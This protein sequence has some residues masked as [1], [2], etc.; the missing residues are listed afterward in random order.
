MSTMKIHP[1]RLD[2]KS[3]QREIS[4]FLSILPIIRFPFSN[5]ACMKYGDFTSTKNYKIKIK[6]DLTDYKCYL[7]N[8]KL[9][10]AVVCQIL[11]DAVVS[12][13]ANDNFIQLCL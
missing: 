13:S 11:V 2:G 12:T 1:Q 8:R 6:I 5:G 3:I 9:R 4:L 7:L 10:L